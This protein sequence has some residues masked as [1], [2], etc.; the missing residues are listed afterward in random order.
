MVPLLL[1]VAC[2]YDPT[3]AAGP[4][5]DAPPMPDAFDVVSQCPTSYVQLPGEKS[6]YRI[7][8]AGG[9][10]GSHSDDCTDDLLGATHLAVVDTLAELDQLEMAID[11][12][13]NLDEEK[14]WLGGVQP[15]DQNTAIDGWL[16][17]TGAP[18]LPTLWDGGEPNDEGDGEDDEENY[19]GIE[20]QRDGLVDFPSDETF[21]AV[22]E[23][24][25][26]PLDAAA[27]AAIDANR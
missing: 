1:V 2:N 11:A 19:A 7:I 27:A 9:R 5:A 22:C 3:P 26:K 6:R 8:E 25:G 15:R 14:A 12:V 24:D 20:R 16:W 10:F 18:V 4:V 21:G 13:S 23:C 17:A